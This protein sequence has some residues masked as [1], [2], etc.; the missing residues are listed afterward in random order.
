MHNFFVQ[1]DPILLRPDYKSTVFSL[2]DNSLLHPD[3]PSRAPW[4]AN[5]TKAASQILERLNTFG[6]SWNNFTLCYWFQKSRCLVFF[7]FDMIV[8]CWEYYK[9]LSRFRICLE[10]SEIFLHP[11]IGHMPFRW[12]MCTPNYPLLL[13]GDLSPFCCKRITYNCVERWDALR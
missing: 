4:Q 13:R 7:R 9:P 1:R 3:C 8:P 12:C 6:S 5:F 10:M 2:S 11:P